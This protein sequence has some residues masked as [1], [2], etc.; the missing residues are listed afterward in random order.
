MSADLHIH[1][2]PDDVEEG[3]VAVMMSNCFG[4]KHFAPL[5][6]SETARHEALDRV[7]EMPNVW[8][9]EV[10]WLKAAVFQDSKTFVPGPVQAVQE[11]IGE[12]L[13][14]LDPTLEKKIL[15]A[16][17]VANATDYRISELAPVQEFL[18]KHR[19][20]RLFTVSW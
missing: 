15:D 20:K 3:V 8:I 14:R 17:T 4:S 1:V 9:G 16:L 11:A 13:P 2:L 12:G 5:R 7:M 6:V 18:A 10:S 19:N